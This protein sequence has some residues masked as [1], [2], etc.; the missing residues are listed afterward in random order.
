MHMRATL[1][2][3]LLLLFLAGPPKTFGARLEPAETFNELKKLCGE[4]TGTTAEGRTEKITYRTTANDTVLLEAWVLGSG[5]EALTIYHLDGRDLIATHY[6]PR[7][8]Q[9]RLKLTSAS[10][11]DGFFF[12]FVSATNLPNPEAAHQHRFEIQIHGADSFSRGETYLENGN[13]DSGKVTY[14][15]TR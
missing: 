10:R 4:W 8:N 6:C 13:T 11:E 15:R 9:P 2:L 14:S 12:E 5:R 1:S 3:T 7:G